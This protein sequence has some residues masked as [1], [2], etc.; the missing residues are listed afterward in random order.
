M[1]ST[2]VAHNLG[3]HHSQARVRSLAHSIWESVPKGRPA[4]PGVKLVICFI[5]R[6]IAAGACVDTGV[7]IVLVELARTGRLGALLAEDAELFCAQA[8]ATQGNQDA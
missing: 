5:Q 1:A 2:V 8:L 7:G 3:P 6:R 4:A